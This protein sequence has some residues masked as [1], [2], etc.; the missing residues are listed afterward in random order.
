MTNIT[1]VRKRGYVTIE[2]DNDDIKLSHLELMQKAIQVLQ[3]EVIHYESNFNRYFNRH[4]D[5]NFI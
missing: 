3:K 1:F 2:I 5:G 4:N